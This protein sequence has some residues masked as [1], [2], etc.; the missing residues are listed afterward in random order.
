MFYMKK[1]RPVDIF[2]TMYHLQHSAERF[3][4]FYE[5]TAASND[6][7][8]RRYRSHLPPVYEARNLFN[9][10]GVGTSNQLVV[11]RVKVPGMGTPVQPRA[12]DPPLQNIPP[13]HVSTPP[14]HY[15]NPLDNIVAAASRL[16]ALPVD[17]ESP[18]AME[19]R[20]ARELLQTAL[21]QQQAYSYGTI[22]F[23]PLVGSYPRVLPLLFELAQF[24]PYFFR[25]GPSNAL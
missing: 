13:Q 9:T 23:L 21:T 16:A 4:I 24:C 7:M 22:A 25:H 11:N 17:G 2:L 6:V 10:P 15:S 19:T 18:V 3:E 1:L 5:K 12:M 8:R 14:G 20:R